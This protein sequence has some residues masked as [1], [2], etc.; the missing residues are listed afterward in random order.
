MGRVAGPTRSYRLSAGRAAQ[1]GEKITI[2][3]RN[4]KGGFLALAV[5][6]HDMVG[7]VKQ[8]IH[9]KEGIHPDQQ[10]LRYDGKQLEDDR[11]LTSYGVKNESSMD[12]AVALC[13]RPCPLAVVIFLQWDWWR[14]GSVD[15]VMRGTVP[16]L[17]AGSCDRSGI[18][19]GTSGLSFAPVFVS[20]WR[21]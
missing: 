21:N 3:V 10:R 17:D 4:L 8:L 12:L 20:P 2:F 16:P 5:S 7:Y 14:D 9:E 6:T 11:T 19:E 1:D 15:S 18:L 13:G